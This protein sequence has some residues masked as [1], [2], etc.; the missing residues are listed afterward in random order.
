MID[1]NDRREIHF[2]YMGFT[3]VVI[4]HITNFYIFKEFAEQKEIEYDGRFFISDEDPIY[5]LEFTEQSAIFEFIND[6]SNAE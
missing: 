2:R 4:D 1:D 6:M 3:F 5:I